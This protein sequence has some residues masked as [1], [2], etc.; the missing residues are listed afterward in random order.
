MIDN[1]VFNEMYFFV[2]NLL[3]VNNIILIKKGK[4]KLNND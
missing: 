1:V 2:L 4:N 3:L